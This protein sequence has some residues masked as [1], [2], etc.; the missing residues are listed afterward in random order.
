MLKTPTIEENL[1]HIKT[2]ITDYEKKYHR[3]PNS[4][5]LLAAAKKQPIAR[6]RAAIAAGQTCFGENYAQE[7]IEVIKELQNNNLEWHYIGSIQSNKTRQIAEHFAWVHTVCTTKAAQRLNDQRPANLPP[8]NICLEINVSGEVTKSGILH[9]DEI[10]PLAEF[11]KTLPRLKLRGLMTIP[12]PKQTFAE[13]RAELKK[14]RVLKEE[15]CTRGFDLDTL[16]MG[17]TDDMEAAI[18]EGAT[19]VRIGTGVFG[20]R[21]P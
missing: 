11:C 1:T 19:I 12:A 17:M 8:L 20:E 15:L 3:E 9:H 10:L 4:V 5:T 7:A 2:L 14:L 18:A 13:Q 6:I 21:M 16:S